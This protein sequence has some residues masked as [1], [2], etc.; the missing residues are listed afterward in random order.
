M[1]VILKILKEILPLVAQGHQCGNGTRDSQSWLQALLADDIPIT[2]EETLC[3]ADC[4]C[5][6]LGGGENMDVQPGFPRRPQGSAKEAWV[7]SGR[8]AE[9][10]I[11][12][13][14]FVRQ[15][16]LRYVDRILPNVG[17]C[18]SVCCIRHGCAGN[19]YCNFL[20]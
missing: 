4:A 1:R 16:Q 10:T 13:A 18:F 11:Q 20:C 15:I 19:S 2:P 14:R 7:G 17:L 5:G 9:G 3:D 12:Y 8:A 6:G